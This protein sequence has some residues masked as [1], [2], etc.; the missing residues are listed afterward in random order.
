MN[1]PHIAYIVTVPTTVYAFLCGQLRLLKENGF[2]VDVIVSPDSALDHVLQ[3][4]GVGL[5][6]LPMNREISP[7]QD[8]RAVYQLYRVLAQLRPQ[9]VNASTPKAG[10]LGM[11]AA[12]MARVPVRVYQQR[13]LRLETTRGLK[14]QLLLQAERLAA[15]S[16]HYVV[17]NSNSLKEKCFELGIA[18]MEK[19]MVLGAG[20]SNGIDAAHFYPNRKDRSTAVKL[21]RQQSAI[22][23]SA[24]VIGYVGRLTRDKGIEDL[25]RAFD[26]ITLQHADVYL[27]LVGRFEPGDALPSRLVTRLQGDKRIVLTGFVADTAPYYSLM[28]IV[29]FPSYREGFPNVPL[30]AAASGLP[31]VGYKATG[32]VDAVWT[33]KTGCLVPV[34]DHVQLAQE[35]LQLL[36][37]RDLRLSM[38]RAGRKWVATNF[39]SRIVWQN[40]VQFY[41]D[42]LRH[43]V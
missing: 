19:L 1:Q 7:L 43:V 4:E 35:L 39:D 30:E 22:P 24:S 2:R 20:S 9:L 21:L 8:M 12:K 31:V 33:G 32:T 34:G 10:F 26:R 42:S 40:W 14:R 13:G 23:E 36:G 3:R 41:K 29:A 5:I 37:N 18:E 11:L 15:A 16:S 17:C 27:L 28:D 25:V 6:E 38:G